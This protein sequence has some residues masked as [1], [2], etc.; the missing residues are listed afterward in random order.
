MSTRRDFLRQAGTVGALAPLA[1]VSPLAATAATTS[2]GKGAARKP[3]TA[4]AEPISLGERHARIAK[5]QKLMRESGIAALLLE[6]GTSMLYF[7]GIDWWRSERLTAAVLPRE[8]D[9]ALVTPYF[10]EASLRERMSFGD[11]VRTWHEHENPF[12]L[13]AGILA[14]RRAGEGRLAIEETVRYFVVEG[15]QRA[16]SGRGIVSGTPIIDACRM[17]KSAH[18]IRLMQLASDVTLAAYRSV[19]AGIGNGMTSA[20]ITAAMARETAALGGRH[21]FALALIGEAS[22]YPH[23]S[24]RPQ[25][26]SEGEI[27]LMDCGCGVH[28]YASD[29]SRT[30]VFGE[31]SRR[32]RE[33]WETVQRGQALAFETAQPGTPAGKVDDTV[34]DWYAE[35][36]YGP[37]YRTPG[38][39]HRL[40][41]GIG[42]DGH[43]RINFVHGE[44]MPLAPGMCLSNEP[45]IYLPGEFGVRLEDCLYITAAGPRWFSR[46]SPAIDQPFAPRENL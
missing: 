11:D 16:L 42:M 25:V 13:V 31:P 40:G 45:G 1:Q 44:T 32:Q 17:Y 9:L 27:V 12:R 29:I 3:M 22:A 14:D 2:P 46:P 10:E 21:Q 24:D 34:R 6:P 36:G 38:L 15:V 28:G 39:P 35:R 23:G 33:V 4:D 43:E 18:E 37:G 8:G 20:D 5:A 19:V 26:V 7:T 30:I 41:H